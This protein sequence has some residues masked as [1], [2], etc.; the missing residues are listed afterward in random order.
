[1]PIKLARWSLLANRRMSSSSTS[2]LMA[3]TGP[4]PGTE[5]SSA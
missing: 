1:M 2:R 3:V 5:R 4:M